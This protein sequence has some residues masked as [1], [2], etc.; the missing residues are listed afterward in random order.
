MSGR[1]RGGLGRRIISV[2]VAV[3]L[4][5]MPVVAGAAPQIVSPNGA[6]LTLDVSK[7]I[8]MRL[9]RA[10]ANV[11]VAD[12]AIADVN[13]KSPTTIYIVGKAAGTTTIFA[14]DQEDRVLLNS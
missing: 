2:V 14:V 8:I 6:P 3:L 11:F 4:T 5:L 9:D 13:L 10:A 7:G 1:S 12:P